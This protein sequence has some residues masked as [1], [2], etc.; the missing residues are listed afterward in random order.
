MWVGCLLQFSSYILYVIFFV[1]LPVVICWT[2]LLASLYLHFAYKLNFRCE[3]AANL[4]P[5]CIKLV[6][7]STLNIQISPRGREGKERFLLGGGGWV[8]VFLNFLQKSR[9]PPTS[10][11]GL[12][13]NP[14]QIPKQK[15][16]TPH[17][18]P[19]RQK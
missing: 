15:H 18:P 10:Q 13:H 5:T 12:M 17:P 19:S 6:V 11:I 1:S 7:S 8:G 4:K 9:G 14:S 16:L 2:N 3:M